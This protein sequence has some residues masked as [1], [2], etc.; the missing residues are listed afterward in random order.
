ML[1][2]GHFSLE[3]STGRDGNTRTGHIREVPGSFTSQYLASYPD[4]K[5]FRLYRC[6]TE[7]DGSCFFHAVCAALNI[8]DWH[9]AHQTNTDRVAIGHQLREVVNT[10]LNTES[11]SS[12]W[13]EKLSN[14]DMTDR[15]ADVPS[16]ADISRRLADITECLTCGSFPGL[17]VSST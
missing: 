3:P 8:K 12:F 7:A 5:R 4:G 13:R 14:D 2:G 16:A 17:C 15:M 6:A 9:G 10:V 1:D 11:W